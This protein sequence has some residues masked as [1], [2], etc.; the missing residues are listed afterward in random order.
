ML[1]R[2]FHFLT[3]R[4]IV[5][6]QL[7]MH[8]WIQRPQHLHAKLSLTSHLPVCRSVV[9]VVVVV[10]SN[11]R[12][13]CCSSS[14]CSDSSSH[15]KPSH[16]CLYRSAAVVVF[17]SSFFFAGWVISPVLRPYMIGPMRSPDIQNLLD[18]D[19]GL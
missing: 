1:T 5:T 13:S 12:P 19:T 2:T 14:S 17:L 10:G 15:A 7:K 8:P 11:S 9:V 6:T 3:S 18:R 4:F 16:S